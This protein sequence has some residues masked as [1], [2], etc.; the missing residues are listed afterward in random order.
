MDERSVAHIEFAENRNHHHH[1]LPHFPSHYKTFISKSFS[2]K[3]CAYFPANEP[4]LYTLTCLLIGWRDRCCWVHVERN[5]SNGV[6]WWPILR[7]HTYSVI[8]RDQIEGDRSPVWRNITLWCLRVIFCDAFLFIRFSVLASIPQ[9]VFA[10][11]CLFFC[12][13]RYRKFCRL[14]AVGQEALALLGGPQIDAAIICFILINVYIYIC[15]YEVGV[16]IYDMCVACLACLFGRQFAM[17]LTPHLIVPKQ[18]IGVT[19]W[20]PWSIYSDKI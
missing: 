5:L 9:H 19:P 13:W 4:T 8:W 7:Q 15:V 20:S 10:V 12:I 11:N 16:R 3:P 17:V 1:P 14:C 6:L 18:I 2:H